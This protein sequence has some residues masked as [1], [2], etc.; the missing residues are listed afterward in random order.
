M[1]GNR[2]LIAMSAAVALGIFGAA[3]A[4]QANDSGENN[5]GGSVRP[6]STDGVNPVFHPGWFGQTGSA[7]TA[8]NAYGYAPLPI[9]KTRPVHEQGQGR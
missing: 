6:G 5:M 8:G 2:T 1:S 3:S 4:A 9:H 7:G